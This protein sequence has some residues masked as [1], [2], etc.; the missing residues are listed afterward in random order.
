MRDKVEG[1]LKETEG[2][3]TDDE[4]RE[5]RAKPNRRSARAR[6]SSRT[7]RT[8]RAIASDAHRYSVQNRG[9]SR[10]ALCSMVSS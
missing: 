5:S 7:Q 4:L 1:K 10:S 3:L 2:K 8:R 9:R 6:N